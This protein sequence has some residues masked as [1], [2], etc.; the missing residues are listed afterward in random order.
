[1]NTI[2]IREDAKTIIR[3]VTACRRII[4]VNTYKIKTYCINKSKTNRHSVS[5]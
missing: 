5:E 3:N 1:M 4:C 2:P